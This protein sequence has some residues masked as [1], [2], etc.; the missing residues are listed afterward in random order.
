M[1]T[2]VRPRHFD[3]ERF[4]SYFKGNLRAKAY[5]EGL[6][7]GGCKLDFL[8]EVISKY[9]QAVGPDRRPYRDYYDKGLRAEKLFKE[10]ASL[11]SSLGKPT[12]ALLV[13]VLGATAKQDLGLRRAI[14]ASKNAPLWLVI[15]QAYVKELTGTVPKP[16]QLA[17]LIEAGAE[18]VRVRRD[19]DPDRLRKRLKKFVAANPA[20]VKAVD[21]TVAECVTAELGKKPIPVTE[22]VAAPADPTGQ[23]IRRHAN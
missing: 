10:S 21:A 7:S 3:S 11:F 8:L 6:L 5:L 9:L 13:T 4:D 18:V 14:F 19:V 12:E 17:W 16:G 20:W 1:R 2:K 23:T 15:L 22:A